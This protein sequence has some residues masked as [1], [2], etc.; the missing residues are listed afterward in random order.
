[1]AIYTLKNRWRTPFIGMFNGETYEVKDT[2]AVP[3][4]IAHHLKKQSII[5]DNPI[6]GDN[7]YRLGIVEIGDNVEP[8]KLGELPLES[9]DRSDMEEFRKVVIKPSGIHTAA[10]GP[11][12][13]ANPEAPIRT[14]E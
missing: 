1:M 9:L 10:P 14:T 13:S 11:R 12:R 4:Y 2:L 3:D 7:D 8:L 5:R 6:T